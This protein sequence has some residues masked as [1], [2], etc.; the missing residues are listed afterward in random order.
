MENINLP[1][2]LRKRFESMSPEE[3]AEFLAE[4]KRALGKAD[5][6]QRVFETGSGGAVMESDNTDEDELDAR[7][8]K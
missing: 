3:Q 7:R 4:R 5:A 2:E 6:S 8:D 1:N